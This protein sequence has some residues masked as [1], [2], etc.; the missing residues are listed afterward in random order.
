LIFVRETSDPLTSLV[1]KVEQQVET[2]SGKHRRT[3]GAYI[4]FLN[5]SD[6]LDNR[7]RDIAKTASLNRVCMGIGA[8]PPD[9]SVAQEADVT[10]VIYNV[11]RRGQQ[12]VTANFALRKGELNE[13]MADA[14]VK[15]LSEALPK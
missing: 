12:H 10:V 4:I 8:P 15:A 11:G 6:G 7:L 14:I 13:A 2:A 1:K 9:Y 3:L 5:N